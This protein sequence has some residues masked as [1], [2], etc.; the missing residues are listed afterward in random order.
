MGQPS[1]PARGDLAPGIDHRGDPEPGVGQLDGGGVGA[2]I[3]REHHRALPD[4]DAV[5]VE[6]GV[7]RIR[8][9]DAGPVVVGEY[10]R[11]LVR[12]GREDD[13]LSSNTPNTV[14][15]PDA[16]LARAKVVG[17]PFDGQY[18]AVVVAPERRRALQD[19]HLGMGLEAGHD[20]LH[21][22]ARRPPIEQFG[23]AQQAAAGLGLLVDE[24]HP[25]PGPGR[26]QGGGE[27]SR[28]GSDNQ[29]FAVGIDG[30]VASRIGVRAE[31]ALPAQ[32][33]RHQPVDQLDDGRAA[34]RLGVGRLDLHERAGV[35]DAGRG[36][37]ARAAEPHTGRNL[38]HP[39]RQQRRGQRVAGI[40]GV[41]DIVE[42]EPDRTVAIDAP[43]RR[44]PPV[45]RP[46][47]GGDSSSR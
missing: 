6:V 25:G 20:A 13:L 10:D 31:L 42:P 45:H 46:I 19:A 38:V 7:R 22:T 41:V 12:T 37:T 34:H 24:D 2:V 1:R 27:A 43:A 9:H 8:E 16:G 4:Q 3:G 35:L 40:T 30:V 18:V 5:P 23:T 15:R 28:A 17:A 39:V 47:S 11:T 36:D 21:P 33:M 44:G 29:Q 32:A 14:A 26:G